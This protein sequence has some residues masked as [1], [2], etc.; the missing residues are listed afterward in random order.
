MNIDELI[1]Q[2]P[3]RRLKAMDG[4]A[5]TADVWD[6]AHDFHRLQD[7]YHAALMHASGIVAGLEVIAGDP[8]DSTVYVKPGMALD[9]EGRLI[10][11]SQA[12]T[13]DIGKTLSGPVLLCLSYAESRPTL[14][15]GGQ[16]DANRMHVFAQ[17]A[18]EAV[19]TLPATPV[20]ELARVRRSD[21]NAPIVNARD[22]AHPEA[23]AIDLRYRASI[24]PPPA[25]VVTIAVGYVGGERNDRHARGVDLLA[26]A[27][28]RTGGVR[29]N[30]DDQVALSGKLDA[31]AL[32]VVIASGKAALTADEMTGLYHYLQAGGTVL[33]ES[34]RH[35]AAGAPPADAMFRDA[36][37]SLGIKVADVPRTHALLSRPNLFGAPPAGF[38]TQGPTKISVADGVL[39][40]EADYGCLWQGERRGAPASREE[41][42]AAHEWGE[43]IVTVALTRRLAVSTSAK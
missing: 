39:F 1:K 14:D 13:Y 6:E 12:T 7:Q 40:S 17:Y 11:L 28:S 27:M 3:T 21:R 43:N 18:L 20:V 32:V 34:C 2:L 10:V 9:S 38:E 19:P 42:R 16:Q 36:L 29:V 22:A 35:D 26:Q 15:E 31:Y 30:V 41:I 24:A 5:V 4:L 8:P 37:G 25:T 33:L 23:N